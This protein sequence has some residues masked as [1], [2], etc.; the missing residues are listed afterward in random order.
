[1]STSTSTGNYGKTKN[2]EICLVEDFR[3]ILE[4]LRNQTENLKR[5]FK[6]P[7]NANSSKEKSY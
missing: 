2:T 1:M 6:T 5:K 7:R 4:A 3:T